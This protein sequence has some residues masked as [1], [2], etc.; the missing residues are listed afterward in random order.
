MPNN[1]DRRPIEPLKDA[2]L[3]DSAGKVVGVELSRAS[4]QKTY[5]PSSATEGTIDGA[6]VTAAISATGA[7]TSSSD[8]VTSSG[9]GAVNGATVSAVEKGN[10]VIHKTVLT[11]AATPVTVRDTQQGGGVKIYDFPEG[12][13]LFLGSTGSI[14]VKTTSILASTLHAG[15]TCNWGVGSVTQSSSTVATTEQNILNVAAF[16]SSATINVAGATATGVGVLTP[17]DGT[18]TPIDAFLNL[19][20]AGATDID[21]DATVTVTGTITISWMNLGDY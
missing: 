14:A 9:V 3:L 12:R 21:A 19:A 7:V 13:I 10:G 6:L 15:V 4:N 11:L 17:L 20:V 8:D 5:L 1:Y 18:T 16:T 2:W